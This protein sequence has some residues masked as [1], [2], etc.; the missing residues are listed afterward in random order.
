MP[1]RISNSKSLTIQSNYLW[2]LTL[3][4]SMLIV[5]SNWFDPRLVKIF[6]LTTDAGT[7]I[8]PFT[9]LL[10]DLITEVYGYKFARRA[11]W[12]GFLFNGF[13]ILYSQIIIHMPSPNYPTQ[14]AIFDSLLKM[15]IRIII[16]SA[17]SYLSSETVSSYI[18]A[19][20]K[21]IM[22]GKQMAI[23][24]VLS[25]VLAS[26]LDS[27]IFTII[28]FYGILRLDHLIELALTMWMFKVIIEIVGLPIS[29]GFAHWLKEKEK[30]DIYDKRTLFNIFKLDTH[31]NY[32]DN[33]YSSLS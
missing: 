32:K 26:L 33:Q 11:I 22:R 23:R 24:F 27:I 28:A 30:I 18:I 10:S 31:Y 29:I 2:F 21:I 20:L 9:F 1:D 13:F 8:F 6:G 7:L 17:I 15:N 3:T 14:N 16:A 19:R 12:C 5:L 4:F 25:T